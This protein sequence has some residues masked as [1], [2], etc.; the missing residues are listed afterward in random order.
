MTKLIDQ[1][2]Y[3]LRSYRGQPID[4]PA[5]QKFVARRK[6]LRPATIQKLNNLLGMSST[7]RLAVNLKTVIALMITIDISSDRPFSPDEMA[8]LEDIQLH[9]FNPIIMATTCYMLNYEDRI[10]FIS[11][12]ANKFSV[13]RNDDGI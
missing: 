9:T 4:I 13:S 8:M 2:R 5:V 12:W 11:H 10:S 3:D 1:T 7:V 6:G